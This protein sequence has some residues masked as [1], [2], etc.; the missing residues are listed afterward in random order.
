MLAVRSEAFILTLFSDLAQVLRSYSPYLIFKSNYA[1]SGLV[2]VVKSEKAL[3]F[4]D[5]KSR[6]EKLN[7]SQN[8]ITDSGGVAIAKAL[9][10]NGTL[11]SLS[12]GANGLGTG[13]LRNFGVCR[14]RIAQ[15]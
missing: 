2:Q 10:T 1:V 8:T 13:G 15:I 6:L 11:K 12:I 5:E 7:I 14:G 9:G 4:A 3:G